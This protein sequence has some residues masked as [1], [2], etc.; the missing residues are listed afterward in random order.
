MEEGIRTLG[1]L[2]ALV[3]RRGSQW[4]RSVSRAGAGR[5]R[6]L[7]AWLRRHADTIDPLVAPGPVIG[8]LRGQLVLLERLAMPHPLSGAQGG[9]CAPAFPYVAAQHDLAAVRAYLHRYDDRPAT[10]R[11]HH[12]SWSAW[13]CGA[14]QRGSTTA[15]RTRRSRPRRPTHSAGRR[16]RERRAARAR[17]RVRGARAA[18]GIRAAGQDARPGRQPVGRRHRAILAISTRGIARYSIAV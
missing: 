4:W 10:Q 7:V 11:A 1:E 13:C 12:S 18:R 5:A 8:P 14:R 6:V 16:R 9:N 15:R 3:Y 2:V 17:S